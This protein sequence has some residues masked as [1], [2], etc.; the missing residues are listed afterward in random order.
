MVRRGEVSLDDPVA[1]HL[2]DGVRVPARG[3]REITL[4]D[5]ATHRSGLPRLP[6]NMAPAEPLNPYA[7]YSVEQLYAFLAS[8]ELRR[9]IGAMTEY[10]NVGTGLLGHALARAAGTSYEEALR[11]RILE[12]LGLHSTTVALDDALRHRMAQG[13]SAALQPVPLWD[14]PTLAGAGALRADVQDMLRWL[15]ANVGE[16]VDDLTR[17][18]RTAHEPRVSMGPEGSGGPMIGLNWIIQSSGARRIIWHNGGTGGFFSWMGFDPDRRTGL[19]VL[20]NAGH[21]VDDIAL[22]LLDPSNPL[23]EPPRQ[24][25]EV[26]V[27][28]EILQQFVGEYQI[29]PNLSITVTLEDGALLMQPTGQPRFRMFA[30]SEIDFFLRVVDVQIAFQRDEAGAVTGLVLHQSGRSTPG[31]LVR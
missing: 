19:V 18:L 23:S 15:A 13:H 22:H 9:D 20:S 24:R 14:L 6:S 2:P 3:G 7:D 21:A 31:R 27:A 4:L 8:H 30:E 28:P 29:A 1:R 16:P 10:S 5:L 11:T 26:Q 17:A 12:P 25:T